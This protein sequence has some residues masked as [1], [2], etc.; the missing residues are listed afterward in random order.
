VK[1]MNADA[2]TVL[3]TTTTNSYGYY[4]FTGLSA[5]T[6]Q[7]W[8]GTKSGYDLTAANQGWDDSIDSDANTATRLSGPV[9]IGYGQTNNTIDAGMVQVCPATIGNFVWFDCDRDGKQD[10]G[11]SG[12]SGVTVKLLNANATSVL[13]T[14]TTNA[15]GYYQFTGLSAGTY[16]VWFG[17]KSGFELTAAN[18]GLYDSIDSDADVTTRLSGP[19][20]VGYGQTNNTIDAGMVQVCPATIGNFVWFDCDRD[21]KQDYGESGISGVTVKLLNANATSVLAT[22]TTNAYGY[23]QF[24]G[25]SAG[26]YQVQFVAKSGYQ[27]TLANQGSDDGIDSDANAS[28]GLS[29]PITVA[30]GQINNTVDAGLVLYCPPTGSIGNYVWCDTDKDGKQDSNESGIG[31]VTVK[32]MA[33]DGCTVLATTTTNASGYYQFTGLSAGTY[34]VWFG[35]RSG[36]QLTAA[37]QGS[38]DGI[39]SDANTATR[40]SGAINLSAGQS[41]NT[42]DAGMYAV[43]TND[44]GD[45]SNDRMSGLTP[46]FWSTHLKAW[47]GAYDTTYDNLVR[48]G[49]LSALDMLR[50]LQNQ[51]K[52]GPGSSTGVLLGDSNGNGVTDAGEKTLFIGL[53]AA[54]QIISSSDS[55]NDARQILM[56]HAIAAQLNIYNGK[57]SAG[58]LTVGTDLISKA[59]EWLKGDGVFIY[60]DGSGGDVD[61]VGSAGVLESGSS[62]TIDYNTSAHAFT[63]SALSTSTKAWWEDKSMGIG[64]FTA[65]GE[66][67]KNALQAFNEDR[68]VTSAD[69]TLVGWNS[70]NGG[71]VDVQTN[72]AAGL[73]TV[74]RQHNVI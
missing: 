3:A 30:S 50:A 70:G 23:Y 33:A 17:T 37:N 57:E 61:R 39:D 18:Q 24:G 46:G 43:T 15:S 25:L 56:R 20:T 41:N 26:T 14:T 51:G 65:D 45:D 64:D 69:G 55:A 58:G 28:T 42:V 22:T 38:D 5:G 59:V 60:G 35:A 16:Q 72:N 4:Q 10:Y 21:G 31:G 47:D 32:L 11:E 36:Y 62:G 8:F 73:W 49:T 44:C 74:L 1:L 12:I 53:T 52:C 71:M 63:S 27:L 34:Q 13:A 68:L 9:T 66:E 7:V 29:G 2:T 67:I 40:L 19:V 48:A 6:Y 54:Q